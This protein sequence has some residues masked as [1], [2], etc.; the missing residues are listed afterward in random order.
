VVPSG[1]PPTWSAQEIC[2]PET[3]FYKRFYFRPRVMLRM[4]REMA[5]ILTCAAGVCGKG[6]SFLLPQ[7][8]T[9]LQA[10][11]CAKE[12]RSVLPTEQPRIEAAERPVMTR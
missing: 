7:N 1:V 9:K 8:N 6:K 4:A 3:G 5:A 10:D 2:Q 12:E 11:A